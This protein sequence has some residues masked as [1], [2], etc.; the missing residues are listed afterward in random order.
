MK[1]NALFLK[2]VGELIKKGEALASPSVYMSGFLVDQEAGCHHENYPDVQ[3]NFENVVFPGY[4][5][6]LH[7]GYPPRLGFISLV[8]NP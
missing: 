5:Y 8:T 3:D 4:R 1:L 6:G 7:L 2:G